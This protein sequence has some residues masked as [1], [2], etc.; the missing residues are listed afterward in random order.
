METRDSLAFMP[1]T[2]WRGPVDA[3]DQN[4]SLDALEAGKVLVLP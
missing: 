1:L 4:C 3:E 2:S